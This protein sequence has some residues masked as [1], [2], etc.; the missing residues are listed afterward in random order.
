MKRFWLTAQ[1]AA[2]PIDDELFEAVS[3]ILFGPISMAGA[4]YKKLKNFTPS[5]F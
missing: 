2:Q 5:S 1:G 3:K 4:R